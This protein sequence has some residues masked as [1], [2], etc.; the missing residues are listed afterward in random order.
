MTFTIEPAI[1]HGSKH[2]LLLDDGWTL[3]TEDGSRCAQAEH[4]ILITEYGAKIVTK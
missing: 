1:S 3:V 2:T 4:T